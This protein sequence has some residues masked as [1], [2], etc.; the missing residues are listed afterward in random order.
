MAKDNET[1]F[2]VS[3]NEMIEILVLAYQAEREQGIRLPCILNG[4]PGIGKTSLGRK[5]RERLGDEWLIYELRLNQ[6]DPTDMKGVPYLFEGKNFYAPPAAFPIVG[7]PSSANG[8]KVVILID[9][10][11]QATPIMQNLAANI[12]DGRIGDHTL[13]FDRTIVVLASNRR[14]HTS[15]VFDSP[16]NFNNRVIH[17]DIEPSVSEWLEWAAEN[18]IHHRIVS[19]IQGNEHF[20]REDPDV[21]QEA[22]ATPR[23]WEM[24]S[25]MMSVYGGNWA[26]DK[27]IPTAI[28][29]GTVGKKASFPFMAFCRKME[30][31]YNIED[32]ISGKSISAPK[33][34]DAQY[35]MVLELS[36][37]V[38]KLVNE[39][40]QECPEITA[41]KT[42]STNPDYLYKMF[43]EQRLS[44]IKTLFE[45]FATSGI[46]QTFFLL[47]NKKTSPQ[48]KSYLIPLILTHPTFKKSAEFY[49]KISKATL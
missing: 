8:K 48:V 1:I 41:D 31:D 34:L 33:E 10:L 17:F 15:A 11:R 18:N 45:W 24:L 19:F 38:N 29:M 32:I 2:T 16:G 9:E 28:T 37:R 35:G 39:A 14:S 30:A 3:L 26:E 46:K 43:G 7:E 22:F 42:K 12:I 5:F 13:D 4:P 44:T 20:Y 40:V 25:A 27:K 36:H 6:S 23:T 21:N 49:M 47:F